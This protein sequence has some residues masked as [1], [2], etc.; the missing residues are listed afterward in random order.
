M[1]VD[2]LRRPGLPLS[3]PVVAV[4]RAIATRRLDAKWTDP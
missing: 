3:A 1:L 2:L 4:R